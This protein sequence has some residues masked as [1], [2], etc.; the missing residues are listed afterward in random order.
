VG[1]GQALLA[2]VAVALGEPGSEPGGVF[3]RGALSNGREPK[4]RIDTKVPS[5]ASGRGMNTA[6]RIYVASTCDGE[7]DARLTE[8][9]ARRIEDDI[10]GLG[11]APGA[12]L[13][14]L[15]EL[16]ERYGAGRSVGARSTA[17]ARCGNSV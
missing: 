17:N 1:T 12:S 16:S 13:G 7:S 9:L 2:L 14:S 10:A 11:P 3:E 8:E 6:E 4:R 15:R 5:I